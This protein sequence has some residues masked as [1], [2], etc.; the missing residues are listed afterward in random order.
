MDTP[1][2][3]EVTKQKIGYR[4]REV[5]CGKKFKTR[6]H[7]NSVWVY[8]FDPEKLTRIAKKYGCDFV[9]KFLTGASCQQSNTDTIPEKLQEIHGTTTTFNESTIDKS[10]DI[11][12]N[13]KQL[14]NSGTIHFEE[15]LTKTKSICRLTID[16]GIETCVVCGLKG[17]P[18]WQVTKFDDSWGFL[19]GSCGLRLSGELSKR[20]VI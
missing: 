7:D 3:G 2:Y 8:N 13:V 6:L 10:A 4:L 15:L 18:D 9:P 11:Q 5:L 20:G 19:C 17:R 16:F 1:E 14:G 12:P